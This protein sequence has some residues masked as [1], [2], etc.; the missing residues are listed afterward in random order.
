MPPS[1]ASEVPLRQV[2]TGWLPSTRGAQSQGSASDGGR[3]SFASVTH[4][5]LELPHCFPEVAFEHAPSV[6]PPKDRRNRRQLPR[7]G[8]VRAV[9]DAQRSIAPARQAQIEAGAQRQAW[10]ACAAVF[11]ILEG[12]AARMAD[13]DLDTARL[14]PARRISKAASLVIQLNRSEAEGRRPLA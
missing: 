3:P 4:T 9:Q 6:V 11:S 14:F 5:V 1:R 7:A 12:E 13:D 8:R 2:L 10:D